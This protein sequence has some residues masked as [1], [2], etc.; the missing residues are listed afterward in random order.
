MVISKL[1]FFT[2]ALAFTCLLVLCIASLP[3]L[4]SVYPH[5]GPFMPPT[6][7]PWMPM[8]SNSHV[9]SCPPHILT[10]APLPIPSG[11]IAHLSCVFLPS[12]THPHLFCPS[13]SFPDMPWLSNIFPH[14]SVSSPPT[15]SLTPCGEEGRGGMQRGR[16]G[17][18]AT[19]RG[20]GQAEEGLVQH[21]VVTPSAQFLLVTNRAST[22]HVELY[23]LQT[24]SAL[25]SQCD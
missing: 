3:S 14:H 17:R 20:Q 15:T 12:A 11:I 5:L 7:S 25:M 9:P 24:L 6:R 4:P 13:A 1:V 10:F 19:W 8:H 18:R 2:P 21:L 23:A 16:G 22:Q